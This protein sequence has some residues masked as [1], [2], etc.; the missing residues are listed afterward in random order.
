[1]AAV[2]V[3]VIDKGVGEAPN[4]N[5]EALNII[6]LSHSRIIEDCRSS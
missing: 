5:G 3:D 2:A 4:Y 6:K 1:V